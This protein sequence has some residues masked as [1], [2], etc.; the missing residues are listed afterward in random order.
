MKYR[1]ILL[2]EQAYKELHSLRESLSRKSSRAVTFSETIEELAGR[3]SILLSLDQDLVDYIMKFAALLEGRKGV[4]GIVLFGSIVKGTATKYSDIDLFIIVEGKLGDY[5]D[6][7]HTAAMSLN[8]R[9]ESLVKKGVFNYLS[10]TI[11]GIEDL[12]E[13][14]PLYLDIADYGIVLY[15]S[16]GVTEDFMKKMKAIPHRRE[17]TIYGEVLKWKTKEQPHG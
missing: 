12:N 16:E 15:D 2:T 8:E 7:A 1:S 17:Q 13:F 5:Y 14:K 11:V 9:R 6:Y 10:P 3:K 4:K